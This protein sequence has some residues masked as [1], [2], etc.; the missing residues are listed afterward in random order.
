VR[1]S[2]T[3]VSDRDRSHQQEERGHSV[4]VGSK[5]SRILGPEGSTC[6]S[7]AADDREPKG[8]DQGDQECKSY[9][10]NAAIE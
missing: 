5:E 4:S 6:R 10:P 8:S 2:L 7:D 3:D 9:P 1:N